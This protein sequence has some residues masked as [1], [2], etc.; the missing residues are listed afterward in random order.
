M[1]KP[2]G[3]AC[4][5]GLIAVAGCGG[6]DDSSDS[7]DTEKADPVATVKACLEEGSGKE[8]TTRK[9]PGSVSIEGDLS[10]DLNSFVQVAVYKR[11]AGAMAARDL[12]NGEISTGNGKYDRKVKIAKDPL[13]AYYYYPKTIKAKDLALLESC[14]DGSS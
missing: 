6:S 4:T 10:D 2:F 9:D 11:E 5:I 1:R 3:L 8:F 13:I 14:T 12:W 7:S